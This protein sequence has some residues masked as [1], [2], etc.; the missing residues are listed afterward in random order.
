[1]IPKVNTHLG[2]EQSR[3]DDLEAVG[4]ATWPHLGSDEQAVSF[5]LALDG[6]DFRGGSMCYKAEAGRVKSNLEF[7][8]AF[9]GQVASEGVPERI[10]SSV[11]SIRSHKNKM[12]QALDRT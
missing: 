4:Y 9:Q 3:R 12:T 10:P 7:S 5:W 2:I 8:N 11:R 6:I 1:M